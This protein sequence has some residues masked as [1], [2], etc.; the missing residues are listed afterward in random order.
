M[1]Q[2]RRICQNSEFTVETISKY[3]KIKT[4]ILTLVN[5]RSQLGF[6]QFPIINLR[7]QSETNHL[8]Q[9]CN[10]PKSSYFL[11]NITILS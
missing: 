6:G 7:H 9:G 4:I 3:D 11:N 5:K 1:R 10:L 2:K 8:A